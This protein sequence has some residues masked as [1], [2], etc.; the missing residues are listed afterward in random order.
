MK[1]STK[2]CPFIF[3]LLCYLSYLLYEL[4]LMSHKLI[5]NISIKFF[6]L[7]FS[8]GLTS[9]LPHI[10]HFN[11]TNKCFICDIPNRLAP[12]NFVNSVKTHD[13]EHC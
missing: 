7:N 5:P 2:K 11:H 8:R 3:I 9:N 12:L 13:F 4:A 6:Q 10:V 1:S